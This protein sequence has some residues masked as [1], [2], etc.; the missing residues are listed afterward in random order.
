[1][2]SIRNISASNPMPID[3][4]KELGAG[5]IT[6]LLSV[7]W[8]GYDELHSANLVTVDMSENT[9]T[10]EWTL[11]VQ[12]L[13]Y[14]EN[15]AARLSVKLAPAPQHEDGT[16]AKKKGQL[17]T[18]DFCFRTWGIND[19]YFGAECKNLYDHDNEHIKRYVDTGVCNYTS[20][21]YGSKSS[22]SSLVGYVL[23]GKIPKIVDELRNEM[24]RTSPRSNISRDMKSTDPQYRSSHIRTLDGS[25][26][27][28]YHLFFD[29]T[30]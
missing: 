30:A 22:V 6:E 17:P 3:L 27:T 16:L 7:L 4:A 29:F 26:I 21:R 9:I 20:G 1:M 15:R 11:R 12:E 5:G 8:Q 24:K 18:I 13:W 14:R 19:R 2:S 10:Q 25:V 28:I 23:S